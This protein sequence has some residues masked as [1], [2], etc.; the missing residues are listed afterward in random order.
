MNSLG[1]QLLT[2]ELEGEFHF[3]PN[4]GDDGQLPLSVLQAMENAAGANPSP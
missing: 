2:G 1:A 4:H 3:N